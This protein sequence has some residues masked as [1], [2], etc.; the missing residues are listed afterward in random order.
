MGAAVRPNSF[1]NALT[2]FT[3]A[4][5]APCRAAYVAR[6]SRSTGCT[7]LIGN[8]AFGATTTDT[9]KRPIFAAAF[10]GGV[11]AASIAG[12]TVSAYAF[13]SLP[14]SGTRG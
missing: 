14:A 10:L 5:F 6:V 3:D 8:G 4:G 7:R 13:R 1:A 9:V 11:A 2:N 12:V